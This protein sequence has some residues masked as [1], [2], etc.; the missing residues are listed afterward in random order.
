MKRNIILTQDIENPDIN[1]EWLVSLK[2][3]FNI[4]YLISTSNDNL[5]DEK[6][7]IIDNSLLNG[8]FTTIENDI[9]MALDEETISAIL[10]N[11]IMLTEVKYESEKMPTDVKRFNISALGKINTRIY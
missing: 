6:V 3:V 11:N 5:K 4:K 1:K 7:E 10:F 2:D 9:V 8:N